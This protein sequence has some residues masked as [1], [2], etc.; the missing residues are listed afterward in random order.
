MDTAII[1]IY[2]LEVCKLASLPI[3]VVAIGTT[4]IYSACNLESRIPHIC[5]FWYIKC[6]YLDIKTF[7]RNFDDTKSVGECLSFNI[8]KNVSM[9]T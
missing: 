4:D 6:E 2:G 8:S 9:A 7:L 1:Y 3:A 5:E